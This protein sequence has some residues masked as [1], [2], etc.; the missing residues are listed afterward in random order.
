MST[1]ESQCAINKKYIEYIV[2]AGY[3]PIPICEGSVDQEK[4]QAVI[5]DQAILCDGLLLPGGIDVEPTFYG[6]TNYSSNN[7]DPDKDNFERFVMSKF[8]AEA[9]PIFGICRGFQLLARTYL[10]SLRGKGTSPVSY[11]QHINNH[12]QVSSLG[13]KRGTPTHRVGVDYATLYNAK[14]NGDPW[15]W[16]FVNSMHHQG[17]CVQNMKEYAKTVN[18]FRILG[19]TDHAMNAGKTKTFLVEAFEVYDLYGS[20]VRA[21]QWH[22]EEMKDYQLLS[23]FFESTGKGKKENKA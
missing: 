21:V 18:P 7:C 22:P 1:M 9:K 5:S 17:V 4:I 19:Y 3:T 20:H 16:M 11:T 2:L 8:M 15:N 14:V 12:S 13:A 6:D 23:A 10:S